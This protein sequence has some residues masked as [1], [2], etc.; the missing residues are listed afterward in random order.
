M[1]I[2]SSH[3]NVYEAFIAYQQILIPALVYPLGAI[4]VREDDCSK[5]LGPALKALLPKLGLEA[6]LSRDI[7]HAVPRYGGPDIMHIYTQA[8]ILRVKMFLGHWRKGDETAKILRISL[9]CCQ[10]E[11]GI[12]HGLLT[13]DFNTYG[14]ILQHCWLKELW[15]FLS[16]INGIIQIED[17][18]V[19]E[20]CHNDTFFMNIIY[21]M[22]LTKDQMRQINSCRLAQRATFFSEILHH[23]KKSLAPTILQPNIPLETN[24]NEIFPKVEVPEKF[25][26]LWE[27]IVKTIKSSFQIQINA[28]GTVKNLSTTRWLMTMDKRYVYQ[29]IEDGY[30]IHRFSHST[31]EG[32]HYHNNSLF[33]TSIE[34]FQFLRWIT[35]KCNHHYIIVSTK[36]QLPPSHPTT[37]SHYVDIMKKSIAQFHK[38]IKHNL[39]QRERQRRLHHR[40]N[41]RLA[42]HPPP[43]ARTASY[44]DHNYEAYRYWWEEHRPQEV[45]APK[46]FP[47][48]IQKEFNF[49]EP[50][51]L[52]DEFV[53]TVNRLPSP[54]R[55]NMGI[56]RKISSLPRI[57]I[58]LENNKIIGVSDASMTDDAF[59]AHAYTII[60][61][62]EK[63]KL[64]ESRQLTVMRTMP[65]VP[66]Q[67][68]QG[69]LPW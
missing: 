12:G 45:T 9:G 5:I 44:D 62:D 58:A 43:V 54:L 66:G 35:P 28:I 25:W 56:F 15:R 32:D 11:V 16:E 60:S 38:E 68:S 37:N 41:T 4:P 20:R 63:V 51:D 36:G 27:T 50:S 67:K 31:K 55:R 39:Q 69:C 7:V 49:L 19:Q 22:A 61:R 46:Q 14:W 53:T 59:C 6:T 33:I 26:R 65:I 21:D 13:K 8:G 3:L 48:T 34:T 52:D 42:S 1:K 57:L 24:V 40:R 47:R 64:L 17:E 30:S 2:T 23:D 10:Q 29:K 18:W